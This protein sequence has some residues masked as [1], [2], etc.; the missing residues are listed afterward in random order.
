[1][2]IHSQHPYLLG[3]DSN[4]VPNSHILVFQPYPGEDSEY[5]EKSGRFTYSSASS[6]GNTPNNQENCL[7]WFYFSEGYSRVYCEYRIHRVFALFYKKNPNNRENMHFFFLGFS[8]D[9]EYI[10]YSPYS[11][12]NAQII[13]KFYKFFPVFITGTEYI[14]YSPHSVRKT[15]I[16]GKFLHQFL[17]FITGTEF[18]EYSPYRREKP[19]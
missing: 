16:I 17:A 9:T 1:M 12:R 3:F 7:D 10:E 15:R 6:L 5:S 13:G 14:G 18:V 8:P 19:E 2:Y 4:L 11:I